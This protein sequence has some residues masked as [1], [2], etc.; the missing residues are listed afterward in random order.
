MWWRDRHSAITFDVGAAGLRAV[1]F[2]RRGAR[3]EL[4]DALQFELPAAGGAPPPDGVDL[5]TIAHAVEQGRFIGRDVALVLSPPDVQFVPVRVPPQVLAQPPE[6]FQ[7]AVQFEVSQA[8]RRGSE[9][10]ELRAWPLPMAGN[11]QPNVIAVTLPAA[12]AA[13]WCA[14]ADQQQLTLSR[15]D[16]APCALVALAARTWPPEDSE[17]WGVL[18]LGRR[19]TTLTLVVGRTPAYIRTLGACSH[20]WT[21]RLAA[22]FEV[23]LDVAEELKRR[24]GIR[25]PERGVRSGGGDAGRLVGDELAGACASV[26]REA[27]RGLSAEVGRCFAYLQQAFP[28]HAP[29]RLVLGGGGAGLPGLADLLQGELEI[30]VCPLAPEPSASRATAIRSDRRIDVRNAAAVGAALLDLEAA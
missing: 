12:Q 25:A 23:P 27:L 18:D 26:L 29:R 7:Q 28:E 4:C 1:Q 24:H 6:R 14:A 22:A 8:A 30:P 10:M 19:H 2:R 9:E 21:Q 3:T 16:V 17:S 11:Q 5:A 13:A 15:I 20:D